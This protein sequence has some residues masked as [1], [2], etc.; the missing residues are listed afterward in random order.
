MAGSEGSASFGAHSTISRSLL[1]DARAE[2]GIFEDFWKV[3]KVRSKTRRR[4]KDN[5][6]PKLQKAFQQ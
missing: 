5:I 3:K 1:Y 6:D 4:R 2:R